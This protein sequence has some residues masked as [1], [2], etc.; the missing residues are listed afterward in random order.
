MKIVKAGFSVIYALASHVK[1]GL[2]NTQFMVPTHKVSLNIHPQTDRAHLSLSI[3]HGSIVA[4]H[5]GNAET[6]SVKSVSLVA[7]K[8]TSS[9]EGNLQFLR[10]GEEIRQSESKKKLDVPVETRHQMYVQHDGAPAHFY[11]VVTAQMNHQF[12]HR[13]IG[14]GGPINWPAT[15]P[16][17]TS[18]DYCIWGWMKDIHYL[19]I[20]TTSSQFTVLLS[21][22]LEFTVSRTTDL[23]RQFTV[24]ELG[25][26]QLRSTALELRS[27]QLRSTALE[28]RPSDAD[29]DADAH[30]SRTP[31][32]LL[33]LAFSLTE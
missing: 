13:W 16:D 31:A 23:Q 4:T 2:V 7:V 1:R 6:Y 14:R 20:R 33:A 32:G 8:D 24:L 22:S 11:H 21:Q 19:Q 29:A 30:S 28:L 9:V 5:S 25:S 17:L 27:L 10:R 26:L 3:K 12:P 18:L 15:S